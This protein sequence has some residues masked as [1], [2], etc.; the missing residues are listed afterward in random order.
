MASAS[1]GLASMN[2]S[3]SSL[4]AHAHATAQCPR[5]GGAGILRLGDQRYRTCLDCLGQ[6]GRPQPDPFAAP[7]AEALRLSASAA[8]SR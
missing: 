1:D 7:L 3:P 8:P 2:F 5:C 6:G 4:H